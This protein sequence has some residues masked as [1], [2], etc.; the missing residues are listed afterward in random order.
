[1][2][3]S[4]RKF[5]A[6]AAACVFA[7]V[8]ARAEATIIRWG[9]LLPESHPQ[10]QMI[11][12]IAAEVKE[13]TSGRIEI[14]AFP[15]GQ[16][17]T[18]AEMVKAVSTG[19]LHLTTDGAGAIANLL[20]LLSVLEAPYIW[21]D[22]AH[23]AKLRSSPLMFRISEAAIATSSM[24]LLGVSYY[25]RR[26]LTTGHNPVHQPA[27]LAGLKVRVPTVD[28]Y[29]AMIEA[30]GAQPVPAAFPG[31]YEALRDGVYDGQENPTPTIHSNKFYEVQKFLILTGHVIS[32]RIVLA[33]EVLF[34]RLAKSDRR[35]LHAAIDSAIAWQD[36]TLL[37]QEA[38]LVDRLEAAGMTI[39]TPDVEAFRR[40]V[41]DYV[42]KKFEDRWGNGVWDLMQE[43]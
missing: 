24:Q 26:H 43:L 38:A 32:P 23:L 10:V 34:Q 35:L 41:L 39:I 28:V 30:W 25:G 31:L 18:G 4:R 5:V 15:N 7:P 1:M 13:R 33:N 2:A 16:L 22:A 6:Q 12:R 36:R 19:A 20:P 17:G 9:E 42:L 14:Q 3:I 29:E 37:D 40:P 8:V 21:R 11:G 27:D